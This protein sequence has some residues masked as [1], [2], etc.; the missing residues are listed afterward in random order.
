MI[1]NLSRLCPK[2]PLGEIFMFHHDI[3][4]ATQQ[5]IREAKVKRQPPNVSVAVQSGALNLTCCFINT[6]YAGFLESHYQKNPNL[7]RASYKEQHDSLLKECFG[8]SDFYSTGLQRAGCQAEDLIINCAPLQEAWSK[9]QGSLAEGL[10]IAVEQIRKLKPDVLYCQD[11]TLAPDFLEAIRPYV[12]LI[13]GQVASPYGQARLDFYDI[14]F[15]SFPHFVKRFREMGIASY[16]QPLAFDAGV[17]ERV[18]QLPYDLRPVAC[19]FVG[20]ISAD[21]QRRREFFEKVAGEIPIDFW[22]YGKENLSLDSPIRRRHYG[23]VWG[24]DMFS[25]LA[26]SKITLNNHIDVAENYANNMRLFE[27]TG[28]GALLVTDYKDNLAELFEIGKEVVAYRS[29]E[30]CIA[31]IKYYL[32]HPAEAA[33][34]ARA[35]QERTLQNHTYIRRMEDT[36]QILDRHLGRKINRSKYSNPN[37][38]AISTGYSTIDRAQIG[39]PL[40]EAWKCPEMAQRQRALV[41]TE[42]DQM[43]QREAPAVYRTLAGIL[44]SRVFSGASLL[45]IGCSSGYYSE[46]LRYLLDVP[47]QYTGVDYSEPMIEMARALY[48]RAEFQVADGARLPY[49]AGQF[50]VAVSSCVL[51]HVPNYPDHIR[52]TVRV[53]QRYVVAHRTPIFKKKPTAFF[54]KLAYGV[55]TVEIRFHEQEI[56]N[57]FLGHGLSLRDQIVIDSNPATDEYTVTYLFEK[58]QQ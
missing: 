16:Y 37:M 50:Y 21:H 20:G 55:K 32:E 40:I 31:L 1:K 57:E 54:E 51:L 39:T 33:K 34:I 22:G 48:S 5:L 15:S 56:I 42:L 27:A 25:S 38:G 3:L 29:T 23:E 43:Y 12:G 19:S 30:E 53:A 10:S 11:L 36:A 8:D 41:E 46:V 58:A 4:L 6:F 47:I 14:I 18:E 52:E 26:H 45:E 49:P 28:C 13:V 2:R 9:E 24:R 44:Q 35:G 17:L 7:L